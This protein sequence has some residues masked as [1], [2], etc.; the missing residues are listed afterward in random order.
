MSLT[1]WLETTHF[2]I[3]NRIDIFTKYFETLNSFTR[4]SH[5]PVY[6][7]SNRNQ[8]EKLYQSINRLILVTL[9]LHNKSPQ[10]TRHQSF[11]ALSLYLAFSVLFISLSLSLSTCVKIS[12]F[13]YVKRTQ[14][15]KF[16][17]DITCQK[18]IYN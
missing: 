4:R 3:K 15:R 14:S 16:K 13:I 1:P 11:Y 5:K 18:N 6:S 2:S 10:N 8:S 17:N 9:I 7:C 12:R